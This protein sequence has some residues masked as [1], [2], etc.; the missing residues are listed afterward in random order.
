MAAV[1]AFLKL[2]FLVILEETSDPKT[3]DGKVIY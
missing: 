3:G 1:N 2:E